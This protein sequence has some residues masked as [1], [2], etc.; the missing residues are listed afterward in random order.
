MPPHSPPPSI[1]GNRIVPCR[2]GGS[3]SPPFR[4]AD[5][6]ARTASSARGVRF[7]IRSSVK[8]CRVNGGGRVG[9]TCVAASCSPSIS[10]AGAFSC[11]IG[12]SGWPLSR[13]STYSRPFF[14]VCATT[15]RFRPSCRMVMSD[16]GAGKSRSQTSC[17]TP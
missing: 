8:R 3:N 12:N 14:A 11:S 15:S 2:L 10:D 6:S 7:V 16:G 5:H 17:F 9:S 1:P 13:S 4:S